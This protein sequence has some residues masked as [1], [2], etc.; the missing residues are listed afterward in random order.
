MNPIDRFREIQNSGSGFYEKLMFLRFAEQSIRPRISEHIQN[1][2]N[3]FGDLI[4]RFFIETEQNPMLVSYKE[5]TN[6]NETWIAAVCFESDSLQ[7]SFFP[8]L[9]DQIQNENEIVI[10][11]LDKNDVKV[12]GEIGSE[13]NTDHF[14]FYFN[15]IPFPWKIMVQQ[16]PDTQFESDF[17]IQIFDR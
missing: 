2:N 9:I 4:K 1:P 15:K 17:R 3:H 5:F 13:D 12:T 11:L 6:D 14:I 7:A 8:Q 16:S 10:S